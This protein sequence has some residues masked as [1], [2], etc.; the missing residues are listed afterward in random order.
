M[1]KEIF[2][3]TSGRHRF[4]IYYVAIA[5]ALLILIVLLQSLKYGLF[6]TTLWL[7]WDS[8]AYV[9]AATYIIV[10]GPISMINACACIGLKRVRHLFSWKAAI[11][12][13]LK[14]Y[15]RVLQSW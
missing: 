7:G 15:E 5:S 9:C 6:G 11:D 8:P 4:V 2:A 12:R 10:K 1:G 13:Y 3:K 14:I